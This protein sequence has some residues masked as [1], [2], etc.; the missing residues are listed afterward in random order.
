MKWRYKILRCLLI[1]SFLFPIVATTTVSRVSA[2]E[3]FEDKF[4]VMYQG[5]VTYS[6]SKNTFSSFSS[7]SQRYHTSNGTLATTNN[8]SLDGETICSKTPSTDYCNGEN[9]LN[10]YIA[11]LRMSSDGDIVINLTVANEATI[12]KLRIFYIVNDASND[13]LLYCDYN[14]IC[15]RAKIVSSDSQNSNWRNSAKT[16][17]FEISDLESYFS[18]SRNDTRYRYSGFNVFN[19]MNAYQASLAKEKGVYVIISM[20]ISFMIRNRE[21][22]I[23]TYKY[24]NND[25]IGFESVGDEYANNVYTTNSGQKYNTVVQ[26]AALIKPSKSTYDPNDS[27]A[28]REFKDFFDGTLRYIIIAVI[29]V[30]FLVTGSM[31]V[32][33]IVKSSDEPE[34]RSS[35]IK[36]LIALFTGALTVALILL[37]Y[38]QIIDIVSG[39]FG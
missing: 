18:V 9:K 19:N 15:P 23:N 21:G 37:F 26:N 30:M 2:A 39:W 22:N 5:I 24:I 31:T 38:N 11:F 16:G 32:V 28:Y 34:V 8:P 25:S 12:K 35:S 17:T 7:V 13:M 1:L 14:T 4:I 6:G 29:G 20:D 33:T 36:K 27:A 3:N 10:S